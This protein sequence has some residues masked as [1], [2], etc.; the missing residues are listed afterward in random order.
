MIPDMLHMASRVGLA[1][2][3]GSQRFLFVTLDRRAARTAACELHAPTVLL[4]EATLP[5]LHSF[6]TSKVN[7]SNLPATL[8]LYQE[9]IQNEQL[10]RQL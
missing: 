1:G 3:K 8:S 6:G 9:E 10:C 4:D 5:R 2:S 7:E